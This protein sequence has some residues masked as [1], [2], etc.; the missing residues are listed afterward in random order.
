MTVDLSRLD[1]PLAAVEAQSAA[2]ATLA[3]AAAHSHSPSDRLAYALDQWLVTHDVPLS[4]DKDYPAWAATLAA[5]NQ[6]PMEA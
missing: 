5:A 6:T 4:T 1:V 2:V 3:D